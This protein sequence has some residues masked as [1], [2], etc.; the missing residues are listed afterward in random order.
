[1][2]DEY[3]KQLKTI[4]SNEGYTEHTLRTPFENLLDSV[5]ANP[6]V[7]I[8]HEPKS[9]KGLGRPDFEIFK[10]GALIGYI[11][12]KHYDGELE[13]FL[14]TEKQQLE[15][16]LEF[17]DNLI[18]TNYR[19][20]I[21]YRKKEPVKRFTLF[22]KSDKKLSKENITNIKEL[23]NDFFAFSVTPISNPKTLSE[24][25]AVRT[26]RLKEYLEDLLSSNDESNFKKRLKNGL[27][28]VFKKALIK[29]L[30]ESDFIDTY[31][32][33]LT[34]GLL[35][36]RL[37]TN[38]DSILNT[39][40]IVNKN[41]AYDSIPK[42]LGVIRSLFETLK[43]QDIP[44][45]INW[46]VDEIIQIL[47]N[48]ETSIL[49][50][51]LS[52]S[53]EID[54]EDPYVY[55]YE[56]FLSVYDKTKRKASGVYYTP[57][58]VVHFIINSIDYL[59][60]THFNTDFRHKDVV[61]L[62]FAT[63]TGTFLLETF[64]KAL[65]KVD[66]GQV[67]SFIKEHLLKNFYG[68]EYLVAPYTI[69][70]LKLSQF[71]EEKGH[72]LSDKERLQIYLTDTLDNAEHENYA[73]FPRLTKE[74]K[75]ANKIKLEDPILV[76]MGN[77]PYHGHST[78]KSKWI[79]NLLKK[80]FEIK[81]NKRTVYKDDGYY[82]VDG[83]TLSQLGEK[84]P[85]WL[86]DDYVKF[87][88]YAHWKVA[89]AGKGLIGIITNH[90]YLENPTFRGM[91][92][93]L[94]DTFDEIYTIDLHGNAL[95]KEVCPDGSKDENVFD[96]KQGV[97]IAFFVKKEKKDKECSIYHCDLYG[98]REYKYKTLSKTDITAIKWKKIKPISPFYFLLPK[99]TELLTEYDSFWQVTD[100]F[101]V[102]GVGMTTARD[103]FVI[104][105]ET[106]KLLD[107]VIKFKNS[108]FND[109]DLHK[110]F[111]INVKKGWSIRKAWE[112]LKNLS[113]KQIQELITPVHYRPFDI[114]NIFYHDS[115]VWRTVKRIMQHMIKRDNI[116]LCI[117]RQA[118]VIGSNKFDI[119]FISSKIVDLNIFRRGGE[120]LFPLYTY[121]DNISNDN[122]QSEFA[123][124]TQTDRQPNFTVDFTKY[125]NTLYKSYKP[126][127]EEILGYIYAVLHSPT[128]R[129]R[130][131]EFLKTDF[132]RIPFTKDKALFD[133][134]SE[135][136]TKL[137]NHHLLNERY[138]DLEA[139]YCGEGDNKVEKVSYDNN[140]VKINK[141]N[142]F[143]NVSEAVWNFEIGGYKVLD[144]YLK[145]RK[146]R[147]L[148]YD[149]Q[150]HFKK[151]VNVLKETINIM[152]DIDVE[153]GK[154]IEEIQD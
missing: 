53:K 60:K 25:L 23:L 135:M 122:R 139:K 141:V 37:H 133:T 123:I 116:A 125:I 27:Y 82:T 126:T 64:K 36:A 111:N 109:N 127:P 93:S 90:S 28:P 102:N 142:Y 104:D 94:I 74:G 119:V 130:Y 91:R 138:L 34:Y 59:L 112:M 24:L 62:D 2:F 47:N 92:Q 13:R 79:D 33:T 137:I 69:A 56:H 140:Q 26:K 144:K 4:I 131:Y 148:S 16:Y 55:F 12:T 45:H 63:G 154:V 105:F 52:F 107:K 72:I 8:K 121:P 7:Q 145:S 58:P 10:S 152:N 98:L 77:P 118:N 114:R 95:K 136:G 41:Y 73:L 6:N 31:S 147:E 149:E 22:Y 115:L 106:E 108:N 100:I 51:E 54:Y 113:E 20:F 42:S 67:K 5:K 66:K 43:I 146:G 99:D 49:S 129:E 21:L 15:K 150:E 44:N 30:S 117:G 71:L 18:F 97:S 1:M 143:D 57:I 86:Q 88:R 11:E 48:I 70:H 75:E 19:E 29:D 76:I 61:A 96:I 14:E 40:K 9:K 50:K 83:Q 85:K 32:Q 68:F 124:P 110:E 153:F 132:P 17:T 39:D 78:N 134:L 46:I 84:N 128:Y 81:A 38:Y 65:E 120:S 151:V 3:F 101:N 87:I 35:L 103:H 89:N 80:G